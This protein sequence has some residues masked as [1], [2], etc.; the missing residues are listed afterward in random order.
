MLRQFGFK[1]NMNRILYFFFAM[2]AF[3]LVGVTG[4]SGVRAQKMLLPS[5][6]VEVRQE[7]KP[8]G[9]RIREGEK[10]NSAFAGW[11]SK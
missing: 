7:A 2:P 8:S 3:L 1:I 4:C 10:Q 9:Y 11:V 5:E 6:T